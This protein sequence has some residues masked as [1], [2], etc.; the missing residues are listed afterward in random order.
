MQSLDFKVNGEPVDRVGIVK[1]VVS[2]FIDER[3]NDRLGLVEF[4]GAAV[5]RQPAHARSRLAP[6]EPGTRQGSA[7][8]KTVPP[9][10]SAIA[11][12]AKTGCATSLPNPRS[13]CC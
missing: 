3:P 9:I 11:M 12:C 5:S 10:G 13:S 7:A 2:K 8:L 4:A 1:S 6:A